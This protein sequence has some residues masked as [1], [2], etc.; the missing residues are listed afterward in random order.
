M[1][2]YTSKKL[3]QVGD[4]NEFKLTLTKGSSTYRLD[5][6][7]G[8]KATYTDTKTND[9]FIKPASFVVYVEEK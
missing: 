3:S 1:V 5:T 8:R 6:I 7:K 9:T 4:N 2:K